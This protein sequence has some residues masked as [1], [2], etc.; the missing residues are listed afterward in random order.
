MYNHLRQDVLEQRKFLMINPSPGE[1]GPNLR[2]I[3]TQAVDSHY[4]MNGY[5]N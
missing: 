5:G 4:Y 2:E 1:K 3:F